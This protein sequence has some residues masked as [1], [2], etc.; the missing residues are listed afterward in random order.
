MENTTRSRKHL[1]LAAHFGLCTAMIGLLTAVIIIQARNHQK[2]QE[3]TAAMEDAVRE[4]FIRQT[5]VLLESERLTAELVLEAIGLEIAETKAE[6]A[7]Q[8]AG[9]TRVTNNRIQRIDTVYSGLLAEQ[10]KRTLDSLYTEASLSEKE[11]TAARLFRAGNYISAGAEY[12]LIAQERPE[13]TDAR[14][15]HLYCLFLGNKLDRDNYRK[16]KDG[17]LGLERNGYHR[18]EIREVLEYIATEE[19]GL[20]GKG[21]NY[22]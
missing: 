9:G 17:L 5:E 13:N 4:Q 7:E 6:L 8:I 10:Q 18:A 3:R 20:S 15:Y 11:Q 21:D 16:I 2:W 19:G 12:A 14:F 1:L 22:Q